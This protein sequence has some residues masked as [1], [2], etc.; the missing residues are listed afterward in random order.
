MQAVAVALF[1]TIGERFGLFGEV[2]SNHINAADASTGSAADLECV[3]DTGA[4]VMAVEVKDRRL[5]LRQIQDKLPGVREKG[6]RELLFL[7]QG[8]VVEADSGGVTELISRQ[9]VT[10]QNVYVVEWS[11]FM[12]SCMVLFGEDGRRDL[13]QHIGRELDDRKVDIRH[14]R[15]WATLLDSI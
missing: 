7:I 14:R 11:S 1:R 2:R 6:I 13:L 10:G 3:D 12:S 15:Q 8:G 4:I 5:E 9:F